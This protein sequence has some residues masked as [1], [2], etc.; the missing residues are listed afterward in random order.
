MNKKHLNG[1]H[2]Q[3]ISAKI[4]I[5]KTPNV[6]LLLEKQDKNYIIKKQ[7]LRFLLSLQKYWTQQSCPR[8]CCWGPPFFRPKIYF[9]IKFL[10][11]FC[12]FGWTSPDFED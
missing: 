3:W 1:G 7:V 11:F 5:Q 12:L 9:F 10:L 6:S 4:S 2:Q 8:D